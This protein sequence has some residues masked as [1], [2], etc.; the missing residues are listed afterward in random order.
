MKIRKHKGQEKNL[1]KILILSKPMKKKQ[2]GEQYQKQNKEMKMSARK[3]KRQYID[4]M[5]EAAE[6]E[7]RQHTL[8]NLCRITTVL[9]GRRYGVVRYSVGTKVG[10]KLRLV[11]KYVMELW[12][13]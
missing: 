3:D 13:S 9:A 5:A 1:A 6:E 8:R 10:T 4:D 7:A 2:L 12:R 11:L